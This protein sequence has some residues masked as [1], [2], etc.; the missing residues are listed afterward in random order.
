MKN[1]AMSLLKGLRRV[2]QILYLH[3]DGTGYICTCLLPID[4]L[5]FF[6]SSVSSGDVH[7]APLLIVSTNEEERG[8]RAGL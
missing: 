6:S 3:P 8:S 5:R 2:E 4:S 7:L 1:A